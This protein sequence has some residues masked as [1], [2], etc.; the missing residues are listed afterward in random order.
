MNVKLLI[1]LLFLSLICIA[2]VKAPVSSSTFNVYVG[3][4]GSLG[5]QNYVGSF[6][7]LEVT[8]G[9]IN[10][11][12]SRLSMSTGG[13]NF[14]FNSSQ[15]NTFRVTFNVS[16]VK[17]MGDQG[18]EVRP[19]SSGSSFIASQSERVVIQ[20]DFISAPFLPLMFLFGI[21]GLTGVVA[22]PMYFIHI[23][24]KKKYREAFVNSVILFSISFGLLLAWLF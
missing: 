12:A 11:S 8:S 19:V 9:T 15:N 5:F 20:W 1:L 4:G 17:V 13:G 14:R 22:S 3:D 7:A 6:V 10:S 18:N 2:I 23:W 16:N 21:V 24:K